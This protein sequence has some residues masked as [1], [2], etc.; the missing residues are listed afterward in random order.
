MV[1]FPL[2]QIVPV[3]SPRDVREDEE[4]WVTQGSRIF[5]GLAGLSTP[6]E[7]NGRPAGD[8]A[9]QIKVI[10]NSHHSSAVTNPTSTPE[11]VGSIPGSDHWVG[12]PA[13]P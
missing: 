6:L 9:Q 5:I 10:W 11:D 12:D 3:T 2:P 1:L 13:L 7:V 4:T 8:K